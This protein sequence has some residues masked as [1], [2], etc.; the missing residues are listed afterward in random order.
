MHKNKNLK[1]ENIHYKAVKTDVCKKEKLF[2]KEKKDCYD[3]F[4]R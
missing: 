4:K 2:D 1:I 3:V